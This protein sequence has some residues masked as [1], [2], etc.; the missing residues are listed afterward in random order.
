[1]VLKGAKEKRL[2][3]ELKKGL[4]DAQKDLDRIK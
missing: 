4:K 2:M 1:M 3:Q